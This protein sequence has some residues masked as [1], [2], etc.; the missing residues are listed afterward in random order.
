MSR[1]GAILTLRRLAV[2]GA[3][4]RSVTSTSSLRPH[5]WS[6]ALSTASI[7]P[8]RWQHAQTFTTDSQSKAEEFKPE[9]SAA[10]KETAKEKQAHSEAGSQEQAA[11]ASD[12]TK[13]A[14][15]KSSESEQSA[16]S[17]DPTATEGK[18]KGKE[19]EKQAA[20][21]ETPKEK[22]EKELE[23]A[24][25]NVKKQKSELLLSLADFENNK[26]KC[27]NERLTRRRN[28]M[29]N[30]AN[31]MVDVYEEIDEISKFEHG[32]GLS[33]S[34]QALQEGV[35]LTRDLYR[36]TLDKFGVEQLVPEL[37]QPVV[38]ARHENVGSVANG[39]LAADSIGEVVRPGW[40]FEPSS[41]TPKVLRKTQVK[42]AAAS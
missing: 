41:S 26:K 34:S 13:A 23:K 25:E 36:T 33:A 12:E 39:D 6:P 20:A 3:A 32:E 14:D 5:V 40:I 4:G 1:A 8:R 30:F 10:E 29:V 16:A 9:T 38:A 31:R 19:A 37:G 24:N 28:A 7:L 35:T 42:V 22:L 17:E 21:K 27:Q 18:G 2:P 15:A 11:E